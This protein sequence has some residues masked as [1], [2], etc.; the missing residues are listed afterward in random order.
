[1]LKSVVVDNNNNSMSC[2]TM[3]TRATAARTC[4]HGAAKNIPTQNCDFLEI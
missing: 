1:M 4:I 2:R 3:C